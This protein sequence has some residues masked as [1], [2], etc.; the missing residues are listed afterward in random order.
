MFEQLSIEHNF[1]SLVAWDTLFGGFVKAQKSGGPGWRALL[2]GV[3]VSFFM[4][5]EVVAVA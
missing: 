2:S 3:K 5:E 4:V 1:L